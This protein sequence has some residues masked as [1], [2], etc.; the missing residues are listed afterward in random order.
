ML[1][2][3]LLIFA[4]HFPPENAIGGARPARFAKYL[5]RLG[6][7]CRVITAAPQTGSDASVEYVPDPFC[8]QSKSDPRWQLERLIRKTVLPSEV[9]TQWSFRAA[10]AARRFLRANPAARVTLFS[11]FPPIG[12]HLAAWQLTRGRRLPWI[13]DFRDPLAHEWALPFTNRFQKHVYRRL[14]SGIARRADAV[15]TNTD[16]AGAAWIEKYPALASKIHVLWNG[17]DPDDRIQALPIPPRN[18]QVLSHVGELYLGRNATPI[19]ESIARLIGSGRLSAPAVRVRLLGTAES[20]CLPSAELIRAATR[21]GWLEI[22]NAQIALREARHISQTSD[23]LLLLQPH[24][25]VQVPGKLFEYLQIGRPILAFVQPASP[26]ERI[27]ERSGVPYR[28][29]YPNTSPDT[30]DQTVAQFF[31]MSPLPVSSSA[32]FQRQFDAQYQARDLDDLIRS[33]HR[34]RDAPVRSGS[35]TPAANPAYLS[36]E[37]GQDDIAPDLTLGTGYKVPHRW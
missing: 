32:W 30:V 9:G 6:Y 31:A 8:A 34:E 2:H 12:T 14:E 21:Q 29:V 18:Y 37:F 17:F 15:L 4:Y 36:P 1:D 26:A 35:S 22:V 10:R 33:V 27:L 25:S 7:T 28:C 11:T 3:L 24:S 23:R 20:V 16:A 19:L 5:T 13:A